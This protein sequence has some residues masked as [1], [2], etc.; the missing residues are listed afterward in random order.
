M[1]VAYQNKPLKSQLIKNWLSLKWDWFKSPL[2]KDAFITFTLMVT[3]LLFMYTAAS[4]L[5]SYKTFVFQIQ[6]A[7]FPL[8]G[9]LAPFLGWAV[10]ITEIVFVLLLYLNRTRYWGMIGSFVLMVSFETY[11]SWMKLMEIQTG[12]RLPCTCGGIISNMGWT[13]H[14]LFNAVF[15]FLLGLSIYY[16][17]KMR[18]SRIIHG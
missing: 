11:I 14:L 13:T 10:P 18:N 12:V 5:L 17:R 3:I 6:L 16:E 7:P 4:K 15:I 1:K 8:I 9:T 2:G